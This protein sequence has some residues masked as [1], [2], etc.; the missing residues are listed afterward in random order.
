MKIKEIEYGRTAPTVN[1]PKTEI[2]RVRAVADVSYDFESP[3]VAFAQLR[4]YV[5]TKLRLSGCILN[6]ETEEEKLQRERT[7]IHAQRYPE[8]DDVP[9]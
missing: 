3:D 9:F 5:E 7:E 6:T 2:V 1:G 4:R 8:P